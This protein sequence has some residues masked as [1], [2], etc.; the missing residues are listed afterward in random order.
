MFPGN[1]LAT[2]IYGNSFVLV[3]SLAIITA[4]VFLLR[5]KDL[6]LPSL[7]FYVIDLLLL[8]ET[9]VRRDFFIGQTLPVNVYVVISR[10]LDAVLIA[11]SL[12]MWRI[13]K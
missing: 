6:Y 1:A 10:V 3:A 9:R 4:V 7:I 8:T 2:Q 11:V 13:D 12:V 5:V